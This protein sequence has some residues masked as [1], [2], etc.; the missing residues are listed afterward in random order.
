MSGN[1]KSHWWEHISVSI[2]GAIDKSLIEWLPVIGRTSLWGEGALV[3]SRRHRRQWPHS[4]PIIALL[5]PQRCGRV[6]W[7]CIHTASKA[8]VKGRGR[9]R[10]STTA[11]DY[12]ST[13]SIA[14]THKRNFLLWCSEPN[15]LALYSARPATQNQRPVIIGVALQVHQP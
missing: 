10:E 13:V 6:G 4:A 5:R 1:P 8:Q 7:L 2:D 14:R 9:E 3:P 15:Q 11:P 12:Y